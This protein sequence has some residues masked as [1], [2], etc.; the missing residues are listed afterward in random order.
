MPS[1][2][3]LQNIPEVPPHCVE[4]KTIESRFTR[5]VARY[6]NQLGDNTSGWLKAMR[7]ASGRGEKFD[8][9]EKLEY[10]VEKLA[11]QGF[12]NRFQP[13]RLAS[14]CIQNKPF[15]KKEQR[16]YSPWPQTL[17]PRQQ[18]L[19]PWFSVPVSREVRHSPAGWANEDA[20]N[21]SETT[22]IGVVNN[23]VQLDPADG[24]S[25]DPNCDRISFW[26]PQWAQWQYQ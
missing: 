15:K 8:V 9:V 24:R 10:M 21:S 12:L 7:A 22:I 5:L 19:P 16:G 25:P 14:K 18:P 2:D 26:A 20:G 6:S 11:E 17:D 13:K 23:I 1:P 3:S 4:I